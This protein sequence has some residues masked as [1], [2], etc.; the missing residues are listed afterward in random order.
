[1]RILWLPLIVLLVTPALAGTGSIL[2]PLSGLITGTTAEIVI[3]SSDNEADLAVAD[4]AAEYVD[5]NVVTTKW[6]TFE[7]ETL[8]EI[9]ELNPMKVVMIGGP[10][11]IPTEAL[12]ALNKNK[13]TVVRI[14]GADRYETSAEVAYYFWKGSNTILMA[15]GTDSEAIAII[16]E[17]SKSQ[18]LPIIYT[19]SDSVPAKV[20]LTIQNMGA[21][22]VQ[23]E[24]SPVTDDTKVIWELG[25]YVKKNVVVKRPNTELRIAQQIAKAEASMIMANGAISFGDDL[26]SLTGSRLLVLANTRLT[27]ANELF[28]KGEYLGAYGH[29]VAAQSLV[30]AALKTHEGIDSGWYKGKLDDTKAEIRED[31][32]A[33]VNAMKAKKKDIPETPSNTTED[34]PE[35]ETP[36]E[37]E[38]EKKAAEPPVKHPQ[39][40][41]VRDDDG[42]RES[43]LPIDYRDDKGTKYLILEPGK[44]YKS[45]KLWVYAKHKRCDKGSSAHILTVNGNPKSFN[46][47]EK[48]AADY[49]WKHFEIPINWLK[50]GRNSFV[51]TDNS[52]WETTNLYIGVDQTIDFGRSIISTNIWSPHNKPVDGINGELMVYLE[53]RE[54]KPSENRAPEIAIISPKESAVLD[55]VA[56]I[57][58]EAEDP[59]GDEL[60][61]SLL[62]SEKKDGTYRTIAEN[63]KND[64]IYYWD[65]RTVSNWDYII[66]A[67]T[68]DGGLKAVAHSG[69]FTITNAP[70]NDSNQT[71]S[72]QQ[73][74]PPSVELTYP[75][76]G[77]TVSDSIN[78]RWSATDPD[79]DALSIE[80]K[81]FHGIWRTLTANTP[82]DGSYSWDTNLVSDGDYK[83]RVSALDG[84]FTQSDTSDYFKISNEPVSVND[85]NQTNGTQ[86][87][88]PPSVELTY[89]TGSEVVS[90]TINIR[91][92][93]SDPD[94]DTLSVSVLYYDGSWRT[95]TANTPNDGSYAWDTTTVQNQNYKV[96]VSVSD[97]E[98][99]QSDTSGYF[100]VSNEPVNDT[101]ETEPD[102]ELPSLTILQ[103]RGSQS[104]TIGGTY[105]IKW[106]TVELPEGCTVNL[107]YGKS[108]EGF[109]Y[110]IAEGEPNDGSY[111]WDTTTAPNDNDY[112]IWARAY[113]P[114]FDVND[115]SGS[116]EAWAWFT[117]YNEPVQPDEPEPENDTVPGTALVV[118]D[119]DGTREA[120]LGIDYGDDHGTKYLEIGSLSGYSSAKLW[121]YGKYNRC[122]NSCANTHRL[123]VNS[124]T[125][126]NFDP[127]SQF[128]G[129]YA[130]QY[131]DIPFSTA[132]K[133]G[134]NKFHFTNSDSWETCNVYFGVDQSNDY[135]NSVISQNTWS[136]QNNPIDGISGELM[137]YL[138]LIP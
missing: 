71:N 67:I 87:N 95:L 11:A 56:E 105:E 23:L 93:A 119:D 7:D 50:A 78:L 21:D 117:I 121:M 83:I 13:I 112:G 30:D 16:K 129:D 6:G 39:S 126:I 24:A 33:F 76:G 103:P 45:A 65:T 132:L 48:F 3:L 88:M 62:Y 122:P 38:K 59:D 92:S 101:N 72:T 100:T 99:A 8:E 49:K 64:G 116:N 55:G 104:L 17:R 136:P 43:L 32:T 54:G 18:R 42:G 79:G 61:V 107:V 110:T 89:P 29:A 128:S 111:L 114:S 81:Y 9:K 28:G 26:A 53:L 25:K 36:A 35:K 134:R 66:K 102:S 125:V 91:W 69:Y 46:P 80:I 4:A 127:C 109:I 52:H 58:W 123:Q 70:V 135:G 31:K 85:T 120:S 97:A 96:K 14:S 15:E 138:E 68:T 118:R 2:G 63:E 113:C 86:P 1:M 34:E 131:I 84:E 12:N 106:T 44:Y 82:N 90:G 27:K 57:E 22:Y 41:L 47:C 115:Y 10:L 5:A 37:K 19:K 75:A 74:S 124:Q 133:T 77:E 108:P 137:I 130:W 98:Y 20:R 51:F 94:G 40:I 73:N 60:L